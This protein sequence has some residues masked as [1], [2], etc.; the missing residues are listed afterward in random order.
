MS[1]Q[2]VGV[3]GV[4][5][6][7]FL[8]LAAATLQSWINGS[9]M[10]FGSDSA[11]ET[12][13]WLG[14]SP[15]MREMIGGKIAKGIQDQQITIANKEFEA[16]LELA[17]RDFRRDKT[18]QV[19]IRI[20]ELAGRTVSHW[21]KLLSDLIETGEAALAYDGQFF[22]DTD[23]SEGDSGTQDNDITTDISALPAAQHGDTTNPSAEEAQLS[24]L[25]SIK[26]LLSFKD[27][28]GEPMN[29][30]IKDFTVLVPMA[31]FPPFLSGATMNTLEGGKKNILTESAYN[32]TVVPSARSTWTD[33]FATFVN[34]G[35]GTKAL[36]R[37][38]EVAVQFEHLGKDSDNYFHNRTHQWSVYTSRNV[39][40]GM[41]QK[42]C[43]NQLT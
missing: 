35:D 21:S 19:V 10:L 29:E 4:R 36:I 5:G 31:Y 38:E 30:E 27:N 43:L 26:Q 40:F 22:F 28:Q 6:E 24:M 39:G 34:G 17:D 9:T 11:V 1:V 8:R 18:G 14:Q 12:Y 41:W 13:P 32:V 33:K 3:A 23:H 16:T 2:R 25:K 42:A 37:Q 20:S 15:A 7:F